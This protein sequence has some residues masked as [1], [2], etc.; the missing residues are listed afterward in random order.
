MAT[1]SGTVN[2]DDAVTLVDDGN[3]SN[4]NRE[5]TEGSTDA[6]SQPH[7][8]DAQG[9][10]VND[11]QVDQRAKDYPEPQSAKGAFV[12]DEG[13][14]LNEEANHGPN[15]QGNKY[16]FNKDAAANFRDEAD[17]EIKRLERRIEELKTQREDWDKQANADDVGGADENSKNQEEG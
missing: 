2:P 13:I 1:S 10:T 11:S 5:G 16:A 9:S 14:D 6:D 8:N 12:N 17:A 7:D 15:A 3:D 4:E